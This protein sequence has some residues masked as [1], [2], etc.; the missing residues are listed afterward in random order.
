MKSFLSID[1]DYFIKATA[2]E[3][4]NL[5]PSCC[6]EREDPKIQL[7][8]WMHCYTISK[9]LKE[10]SS[11]Q[12]TSYIMNLR[13]KNTKAYIASSHSK[14]YDLII[15]TTKPE[16]EFNVYNVDF[17]HDMYHYASSSEE[18]NCGNWARYLKEHTRP[19]MNYFWCPREDSDK[20]VI[21]DVKVEAQEMKFEDIIN[22]ANNVD[23]VFICRSDLWTPPHLDLIFEW[24]VQVIIYSQV[25]EVY[26]LEKVRPRVHV[27]NGTLFFSLSL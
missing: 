27:S 23:Y 25:T 1:W 11:I 8:E 15:K 18:V 17:H 22:A 4:D 3:R 21:G 13:G 9:K 12:Q 20:R 19:N 2:Q 24:Q 5:F 16:E 14:I 26:F 10:I 7:L 6:D